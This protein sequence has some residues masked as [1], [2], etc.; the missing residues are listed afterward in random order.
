MGFA[1]KAMDTVIDTLS[2]GEKTR[3]ALAKLLL[4]RPQLLIL[5]EPTNHLDFETL[6]WLE[7]YLMGYKGALLIV[8][9]DRYFL[10]KLVTKTW[11]LERGKLTVYPGNYT[12]FLQL[13]EEARIRRQKE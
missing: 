9:H 6:I 3:L 4:E 1:D 2:G 8:S 13:K 10:D 11:E 7:E 5:D 12:K